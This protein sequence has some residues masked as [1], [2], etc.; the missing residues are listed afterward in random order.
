MS[1]SSLIAADVASVLMD[2]AGFAESV[3]RY[4]LGDTSSGVSALAVFFEQEAERDVTAGEQ[5]IRRGA[6][7]LSSSVAID[8]RDSWSIRGELWQTIAVE[9]AQLGSRIVQ[10]QRND[11]TNTRRVEGAR[12]L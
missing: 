6:I 8:T 7:H 12:L 5:V 10:V 4:P 2:D 11:K 9:S 3:T 1:L